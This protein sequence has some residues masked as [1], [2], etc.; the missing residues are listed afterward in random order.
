MKALRYIALAALSLIVAVNAA[1]APVVVEFVDGSAQVLSGGAWKNLDFDDKFDSSQSVKLAVGAVLELRGQTGATV[2]I[3]AP[4][5]YLVESLFK[6]MKETSALAT[7]AGKLEKMAKGGPVDQTVAG[8]RG[9]EAVVAKGTMWAGGTVEA[10]EAAKEALEASQ[11]GDH[12]GAYSLYMEA[13]ALYVDASD[14]TG[15]ARSAYSASLSALATGSG[16]RALAA[17]RSASPEDAG[18][19]RGSYALALAALS[20]RYGAA[21]DAKAL[22]DTAIPAGWFD[23]PAVL[24]DAKALRSGL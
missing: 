6:P 2:A 9:S 14:P 22:L 18:A 24:A 12:A 20:A 8:V 23:D 19:L 17:L 5:T 16:A 15:A 7:V 13:F 21:A 11:K 1:A 4:G 10:D 3:A